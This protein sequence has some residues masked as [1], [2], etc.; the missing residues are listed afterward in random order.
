M[1]FKQF[2]PTVLSVP[3]WKNKSCFNLLPAF[4]DS[5]S[6][7]QNRHKIFQRKLDKLP[8]IRV[9]LHAKKSVFSPFHGTSN[10]SKDRARLKSTA[11]PTLNRT[12]RKKAVFKESIPLSRNSFFS[13]QIGNRVAERAAFS[14]AALYRAIREKQLT[15]FYQPQWDIQTAQLSGVEALLRWQH[16]QKGLLLPM[17]FIEQLEQA[18]F[19]L[20]LT[21]ALLRQLRTDMQRLMSAPFWGNTEIQKEKRSLFTAAIN[22]S[23]GQ[24]GN[25]SFI[26]RLLACQSLCQSGGVILECEITERVNIRALP[27]FFSKLRRLQEAGIHLALDDFGMGFHDEALLTE[28]PIPFKIKIPAHV[29]H[30]LVNQASARS[31]TGRLI[32]KAHNLGHTVTAEGIETAEQMALLKKMGCDGG[33]GFWACPP[34]PVYDLI[35][36]FPRLASFLKTSVLLSS[37]DP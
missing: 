30:N 22:L 27:R 19:Y 1:V 16:P 25:P 14:A 9:S 3:K 37:F 15:Y 7:Q 5:A 23:T 6:F 20:D 17:I 33:Q 21:A 2:K 34:L 10:V 29:V 8:N 26:R 13:P 18:P 11:V 32:E 36:T 28:L 31:Q 35:N 4:L 24:L 12:V